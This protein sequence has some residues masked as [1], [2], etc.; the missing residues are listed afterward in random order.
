MLAD[1][2]CK[3]NRNVEKKKE[4][5]L[6]QPHLWISSDTHSGKKQYFRISPTATKYGIVFIKK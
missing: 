1:V 6:K 5:D 3:M 2:G 4:Y